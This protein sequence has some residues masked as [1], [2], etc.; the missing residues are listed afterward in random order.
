MVTQRRR[1]SG[2][3]RETDKI[4]WVALERDLKAAAHAAWQR[5]E[6]QGHAGLPEPENELPA[7][8]HGEPAP[9]ATPD[10]LPYQP[11]RGFD[12]RELEE[13]QGG[14]SGVGP[15]DIGSGAETVL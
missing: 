5:Y 3:G 1:S 10:D 13:P 11:R 15:H 6:Q 4:R 7:N 8:Q 12:G 2:V 14:G 9:D